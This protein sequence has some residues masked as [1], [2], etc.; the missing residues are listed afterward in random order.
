IIEASERQDNSA[1]Q[2]DFATPEISAINLETSEKIL[3]EENTSLSA[4]F[5]DYIKM[6]TGS[7]VNKTANWRPYENEAREIFDKIKAEKRFNLE[8]MCLHIAMEIRELG[9]NIKKVTVQGFYERN[10]KKKDSYISTLDDIG[11]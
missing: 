6:L 8:E 3:P 9:G 7:F 10:I 1:E 4:D 2:D 5:E 11:L